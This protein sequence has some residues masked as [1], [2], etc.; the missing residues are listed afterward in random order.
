M[1]RDLVR[2][3]VSEIGEASHEFREQLPTIFLARRMK[4]ELVIC[5]TEVPDHAQARC[6]SRLSSSDGILFE[7]QWDGSSCADN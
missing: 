2:H 6:L 3:L 4:T 5:P 7:K 1:P